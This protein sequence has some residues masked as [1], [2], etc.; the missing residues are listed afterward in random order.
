[1]LTGLENQK[2]ASSYKRS[3]NEDKLPSRPLRNPFEG[4]HL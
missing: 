1:M 4:D 3:Y 2:V